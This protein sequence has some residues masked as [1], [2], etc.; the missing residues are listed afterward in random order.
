MG[1]WLSGALPI[2]SR[3]II[4]VTLILN[5]LLKLIFLET[6]ASS[7][8]Y[9]IVDEPTKALL[10]TLFHAISSFDESAELLFANCSIL[11]FR[12]NSEKPAVWVDCY[13]KDESLLFV[14][15]KEGEDIRRYRCEIPDGWRDDLTKA[16]MASPQSWQ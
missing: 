3:I 13:I 14:F 9:H 15:K 7:L 1:R 11:S 8:L 12:P 10:N 2:D 16:I 6:G 5:P 4:H